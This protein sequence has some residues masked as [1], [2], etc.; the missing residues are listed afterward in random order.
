MKFFILLIFW[1]SAIKALYIPRSSGSSFS[2]SGFLPGV[3]WIGIKDAS[4]DQEAFE[5]WVLS[6]SNISFNGILQNIGGLSSIL[7]TSEVNYGVV[8]A[9]PSKTNPD[10][11][12]QWTRDSALTLRSLI[13]WLDDHE[14][15]SNSEISKIVESYIENNYHLQRL[16]NFSGD[17]NDVTK[18]SLGEP[19]FHTNGES[20]NQN[21]GRPQSDGPGLR[22][23]TI[24]NYFELLNK[25]G[26][27]ITNDFLK[28]DANIYF[29]IIKFDLIYIINNWNINSFDLWEEINSKHFFNS[30][31]Q[32]R[33]LKDGITL[34]KRY[35]P[36]N[37]DFIKQLSSIF[38]QLKN[39]I[40]NE[41]GF[42]NPSI[43]YL[44]ETPP[45]LNSGK[46]SGLDAATL[47]GSIHSHNLENSISYEDIP[48]DV[49]NNYIFNTVISMV[50]DMKYRYPI[51]HD[52]IRFKQNIGVGLGRYPEDV[53]DGY[54]SSE[55]NPWF[56]STA[57]AAEIF[58]KT[59]FKYINNK[60]DI[61]INNSNKEFFKLFFD[62]EM[63]E[64][65]DFKVPFNTPE[66]N[67]LIKSLLN[68]ADSFLII[69]KDHV[70]SQNGD[71]LE[72][73]NKYHGYMQGA[74][75][76]TWSFSSFYNSVRWRIKAI[77]SI[78][79]NLN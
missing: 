73:F 79:D 37:E 31:T 38:D 45:L 44:V 22:I 54:G 30:I 78:N 47:L 26:K 14:F 17:F 28:N 6:Q 11:F 76:L 25:Y 40:L 42:T 51:N 49:N 77:D 5:N 59:I 27:S 33:A 35:E 57:T 1:L 67:R 23:S 39:Y 34:V 71:I 32:L 13:Y 58:Y 69:I 60:E 55:G 48:F 65:E 66:F 36:H 2:W 56:I 75:K 63:N 29:K 19:K 24:F 10:Y 53:Y 74:N 18:K 52:K 61:L 9:S 62:D 20:F 12:Y 64:D 50:S 3:S 16:P 4:D 70:D 72:Q 7:S 21:W 43:P 46:R 68:Y 15:P 8:V 41:S